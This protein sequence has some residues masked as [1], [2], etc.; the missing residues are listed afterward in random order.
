MSDLVS[1]PYR[2]AI[3]SDQVAARAS[4]EALATV[5]DAA[6]RLFEAGAW[7]SQR[8]GEVYAQLAYMRYDAISVAQSA[9][10]EFAVAF[11]HQSPQVEP[12]AGRRTGVGWCVEAGLSWRWCRSIWS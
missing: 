2:A 12:G 7:D 8:A 5:L 1:N 6:M 11:S 4:E 10:D 3:A 9:D